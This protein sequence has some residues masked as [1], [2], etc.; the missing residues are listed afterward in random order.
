MT[1]L[2]LKNVKQVYGK[3][4]QDSDDSLSIYIENGYIK[5]ILPY[6]KI[7]R[8]SERVKI[9]NVETVDCSDMIALPGYVDS[10][11]HLLFYGTREDEFYMRAAGRP[12]MEILQKGG[13]IFNTVKSVRSASEEQLL[14]NGLKYL[15][16]ALEAGVTTIEIKS[17]YGLDYE[18]EKKMLAVINKLHEMHPVDIV[19]TFL[20]HSVP[21]GADRKQYID[22]VCEKMMPE[23]REYAEW[24]DIFVEK[25]VF[26]IK[27]SEQILKRA[28]DNGYH[29]GM[30]SNQIYD[31]GGVKLASDLGVRH[32]DHLE[33]LTEKDAEIIIENENLYPVFLPGAE[34]Y[35]F[36]KH[37]GRIDMLSEIPDR[38]V[39]STDFNPGS[40]PVISPGFIQV[41][42]VLR[43][44]ISVP[45][46]LVDAFTRNPAEMLYLS[47]RGKIAPG[48]LADIVCFELDCFE[49]IPY[50]GAMNVKKQIVKRGKLIRDQ[51]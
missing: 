37:T 17:G 39:L 47:D 28:L 22:I 42:G 51:V 6:E 33:V 1:D 13:G 27:E 31:I 11:T 40:S 29:T 19:P 2:L 18:N 48:K 20:V 16:R 45:G 30:H 46:L 34:A 10:H 49:Q 9:E 26:D 41:L 4:F 25:N 44:R 3:E 24:F 12:Y 15:D 32:I 35:V 43:Y 14:K 5:H 23:F 38:I 50:F 7:L 36:S 21:K 8:I